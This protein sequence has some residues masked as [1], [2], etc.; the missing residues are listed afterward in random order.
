MGRR[1]L[2]Y[3]GLQQIRT[4]ELGASRATHL[5]LGKSLCP[6]ERPTRLFTGSPLNVKELALIVTM[7]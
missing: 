6:M 4:Y 5:V 2:L 3:F 1:V 7:W